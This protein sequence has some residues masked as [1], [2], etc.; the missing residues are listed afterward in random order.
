MKVT[1]DLKRWMSP[2]DDSLNINSLTIPGTH[3]SH[4]LYDNITDDWKR[5][6]YDWIVC[7]Q[8]QISTQLEQGVRYLDLRVF[9]SDFK[10]CHGS[11]ELNG[12]LHDIL[13]VIDE[14]LRAN[15]RETI[16]VSI[17]DDGNAPDLAREVWSKWRTYSWYYHWRWPTLGEARGKAVLLRRFGGAS[18]GIDWPLYGH[19]YW[20]YRAPWEQ[21]DNGRDSNLLPLTRYDRGAKHLA[22][23][24]ERRLH[25][26][27]MHFTTFADSGV[28]PPRGYAEFTKRPER[29]TSLMRE[30]RVDPSKQRLGI[31]CLDFIDHDQCCEI[32]GKNHGPPRP[33][34]I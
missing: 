7:Q 5:I 18:F 24:K 25:D 22:R 2:L 15:P 3:D 16:L 27:W 21:Q 12:R 6:G 26:L 28:I 32:V 33:L 29:F 34:M 11:A 13:E 20:H 14:F 1:T 31:V 19:R 10:M 17:K 8:W 30:L 23:V 9:D 4:A